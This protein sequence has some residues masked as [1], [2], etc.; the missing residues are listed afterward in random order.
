MYHTTGTRAIVTRPLEHLE[1]PHVSYPAIA[2]SERLRQNDYFLGVPSEIVPAA[3][4][5]NPGHNSNISCWSQ[6]AAK[7][8]VVV[9]EKVANLVNQCRIKI[10]AVPPEP[11]RVD[12][13][14]NPLLVGIRQ[15]QVGVGHGDDLEGDPR[16]QWCRSMLRLLPSPVIDR[17]LGSPVE[18]RT[19]Q[20]LARVAS[21]VPSA[22]SA[23]SGALLKTIRSMLTVSR[24]P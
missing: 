4:L 9:A 21:S 15:A 20:H 19:G 13:D 16:Q 12:V 7:F 2:R 23:A 18:F 1:R 10:D 3:A 5:L 17:P 6:C 11:G 22:T 8:I 14:L 24:M